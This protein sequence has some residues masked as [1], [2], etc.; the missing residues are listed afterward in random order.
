MPETA[1]CPTERWETEWVNYGDASPEEHGG[2]FV[3]WDPDA[4]EWNVVQ[5]RRAMDFDPRADDPNV[6]LVTEYNF[7]PQDVFVDGEVDAGFTDEMQKI[8]DRLGE[9]HVTPETPEFHDRIGYYV[10]DFVYMRNYH[11]TEQYV[12]IG[13]D[14]DTYED[15]IEAH[16]VDP[17]EALG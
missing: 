16:G 5:T 9:E 6:H 8:L 13:D 3:R 4:G 1:D 12:D 15:M 14:F 7:E 10:V 11:C 2:L 17:A